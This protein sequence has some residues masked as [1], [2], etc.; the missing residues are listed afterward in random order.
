MLC[1]SFYV[2]YY[3]VLCAIGVFIFLCCWIEKKYKMRA[4]RA[5]AGCCQV[6]G[7]DLRATREQCPECGTKADA[8]D[9]NMVAATAPM[10]TRMRAMLVIISA[11]AG[12][13]LLVYL[14]IL[15]L[16]FYFGDGH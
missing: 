1:R 11:V 4:L 7:Y 14:S 5:A 8:A 15:M 6:C 3:Y 13:V 12:C 16:G 10:P 2:S 9:P